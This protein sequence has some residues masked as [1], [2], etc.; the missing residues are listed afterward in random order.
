MDNQQEQ[1]K[2][3]P[4]PAKQTRICEHCGK[5]LRA[6]GLDRANGKPGRKGSFNDWSKRKY[7]K[8]CYKEARQQRHYQWVENF[9]KQNEA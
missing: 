3:K 6:I 8:K 9:T 1:P 7:H 5:P 2:P 4:K